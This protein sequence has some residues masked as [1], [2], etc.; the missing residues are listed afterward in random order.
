MEFDSQ[1][2]QSQLCGGRDATEGEIAHAARRTTRGSGRTIE[3]LW[4]LMAKNV[5]Q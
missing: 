1:A 3:R 2:M 4:V 5:D